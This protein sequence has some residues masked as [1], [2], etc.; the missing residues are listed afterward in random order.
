M[1]HVPTWTGCTGISLLRPG[2][3]VIFRTKKGKGAPCIG[4]FVDSVLE[5]VTVD[6]VTTSPG[7]SS[8]PR[9]LRGTSR[10]PSLAVLSGL[11]P[12]HLAEHVKMSY[13]SLVI[14]VPACFPSHGICLVSVPCCS[15]DS[16]EPHCPADERGGRRAQPIVWTDPVGSR[17]VGFA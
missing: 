10:P 17:G 6:R 15:E 4:I 11:F 8:R 12:H 7:C 2:P 3:V 9:G 1:C 13:G 14:C 5:E 16:E